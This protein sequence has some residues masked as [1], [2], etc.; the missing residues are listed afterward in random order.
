MGYVAHTE[1]KNAYRIPVKNITGR[2]HVGDLRADNKIILKW[3]F[4]TIRRGY[5]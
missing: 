2:D 3:A 1:I 5:A 4:E